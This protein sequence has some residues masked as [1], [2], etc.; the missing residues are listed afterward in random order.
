[1]GS[2]AGQGASTAAS[3]RFCPS[4]P[5]GWGAA[6]AEPARRQGLPLGWDSQPTSFP[7]RFESLPPASRS[8]AKVPVV[9][10]PHSPP[11]H[12]EEPYVTEAGREA[13]DRLCRLHRGEL[14]VLGG[15]LPQAARPVLVKE[16]ELVKDALNVLIG[17][18]SAT[19]PLCQVRTLARR[20]SG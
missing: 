3:T 19:F 10:S 14:Q 8:L 1:M 11:G 2:G 7:R 6:S 4:R 16:Q 5:N 20:H 13:F 15:G 17:V 9:L 18:V 12:R